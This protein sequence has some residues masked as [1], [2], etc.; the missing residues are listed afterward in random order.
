MIGDLRYDKDSK[1]QITTPA[2]LEIAGTPARIYGAN[3]KLDCDTLQ[4]A[5]KGYYSRE[6]MSDGLTENCHIYTPLHKQGTSTSVVQ[7]SLRCHILFLLNMDIENRK[8]I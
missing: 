6:S 7:N 3:G 5:G 1:S 2:Q 4:L 8:Q